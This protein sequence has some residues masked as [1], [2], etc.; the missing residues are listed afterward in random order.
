MTSKVTQKAAQQ[1]QREA[2]DISA[3]HDSTTT[4]TDQAAPT[5]PQQKTAE[6]HMSSGKNKKRKREASP[7]HAAHDTPTPKIENENTRKER[8]KKTNKRKRSPQNQQIPPTSKPRIPA[9]HPL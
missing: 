5:L 9:T 8:P 7:H 3:R 4:G 1:L 2:K 6:P